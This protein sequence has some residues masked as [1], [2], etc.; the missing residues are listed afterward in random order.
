MHGR[1]LFHVLLVLAVFALLAPGTL[2]AQC[3]VIEIGEP[4]CSG[5]GGGGGSGPPSHKNQDCRACHDPPDQTWTGN[6][7]PTFLCQQGGWFGASPPAGLSFADEG[8]V[9]YTNP[10]DPKKDSTRNNAVVDPA[11]GS[12][13]FRIPLDHTFKGRTT[14]ISLELSFNSGRQQPGGPLGH[15]WTGSWYH[16]LVADFVDDVDCF[17]GIK[18]VPYKNFINSLPRFTEHHGGSSTPWTNLDAVEE[19]FAFNPSIFAGSPPPL[20]LKWLPGTNYT[21]TGI[22]AGDLAGAGEIIPPNGLE[23][24]TYRLYWNSVHFSPDQQPPGVPGDDYNAEP[25]NTSAMR[26]LFTSPMTRG[27]DGQGQ[28]G[29]P[30]PGVEW[31]NPVFANFLPPLGD[32]RKI[33]VACDSIQIR[34]KDGRVDKFTPFYVNGE[35]R[36]DPQDP[37]HGL[38]PNRALRTQCIAKLVETE[39]PTGDRIHYLYDEHSR[40]EAIEDDLGRIVAT[41]FYEESSTLGATTRLLGITDLQGR[42]TQFT[43]SEDNLLETLSMPQTGQV[44]RFEYAAH[45]KVV[46]GVLCIAYNIAE[47]IR[48]KGFLLLDDFKVYAPEDSP[49]EPSLRAHFENQLPSTSSETPAWKEFPCIVELDLGGFPFGVDLDGDGVDDYSFDTHLHVDYD[50]DFPLQL[51]NNSTTTVTDSLGHERTHVF[52]W[53]GREISRNEKV[54]LPTSTET[55]TT[56]Y[57]YWNYHP[58]MMATTLPKG[59]RTELLYQFQ[60]DDQAFKSYYDLGTNARDRFKEGNLLQKVRRGFS[61]VPDIVESF[62]YEPLFNQEW[63]HTDP[64]SKVWNKI[65]D[66]QELDVFTDPYLGALIEGWHIDASSLQG[67]IGLGDENGDSRTDQGVGRLIKD[68]APIVNEG[69]TFELYG[70]QSSITAY[71]YNDAGQ[72]L[73]KTDPAGSSTTYEYYPGNDANGDGQNV[74]TNPPNPDGEGFL[75]KAIVDPLGLALTTSYGY[76]EIGNVLWEQDPRGFYT[77][78]RFNESDLLVEEWRGNVDPTILQTGLPLGPDYVHEQN[79]YDLNDNLREKRTR[80]DDP[81]LAYEGVSP[82]FVTVRYGYDALDQVRVIAEEVYNSLTQAPPTWQHTFFHYDGNGKVTKEVSPQGRALSYVYDSLGRL[83]EKRRHATLDPSP[84]FSAPPLPTDD[85]PLLEFDQDA[86]GNLVSVTTVGETQSYTSSIDYDGFDRRVR[87]TNPLGEYTEHTLDPAGNIVRAVN[88]GKR[89]H[90]DTSSADLRDVDYLYDARNQLYKLRTKYFQWKRNQFDIW[91]ISFEG[92]SES[93]SSVQQF[94][95]DERGLKTVEKDDLGRITSFEHDAAGREK[96][97]SLPLV[98][99]FSNRNYREWTYDPSG[100]VATE[101]EREF[102]LSLGSEVYENFAAITEYDALNRKT[103]GVQ[104][105][106]SADPIITLSWWSSLGDEIKTLNPRGMGTRKYFDTLHREVITQVGFDADFD[107]N[108]V[109]LITST[110]NPDGYVRV[111]RT[112]DADGKVIAQKDDNGNVTGWTFDPVGRQSALIHADGSKETL[113][114]LREGPIARLSKTYLSGGVDALFSEAL[115]E[116]DLALRKTQAQ[117]NKGAGSNLFGVTQETFA[118]DGLGRVT[119]ATALSELPESGGGTTLLG[120]VVDKQYDSFDQVRFDFQSLTIDYDVGTDFSFSDAVTSDYDTLGN[121]TDVVASNYHRSYFYDELKRIE[122]IR[123]D[124]GNWLH[125]LEYTGPGKRLSIQRNQN[126]SSTEAGYGAYDVHRRLLEVD[127]YSPTSPTQPFAAFTYEYDL[128]SNQLKE[129]KLHASQDSHRFEYDLGNRLTQFKEGEEGVQYSV[130]DSFSL[131]GVGN[132]RGH[133][134]FTNPVNEVH[135]YRDESS[136]NFDGLAT[137]YDARGNLTQYGTKTFTYDAKGRIVQASVGGTTQSYAFDAE[138]RRILAEGWVF[139][140]EGLREIKQTK[141][142]NTNVRKA[143]TYGTGLDEVLSC[144]QGANVYT[145]HKNRQASTVALTNAAGNL[146]ETYDYNP[147]GEVT[148]TDVDGGSL[149]GNP[150]LYAGRR[151]DAFSGLYFMRARYYLPDMGRF[152]SRDPI[153]LWGDLNNW[154]NPFNYGGCNPLS[155]TDLF[156]FY[157]EENQ[158]GASCTT[159]RTDPHTGRWENAPGGPSGFRS[160]GPVE[161]GHGSLEARDVA[162]SAAAVVGSLILGVGVIME[163]VEGNLGMAVVELGTD[164][165]PIP[166]DD[167]AVA[168]T[169]A[170]REGIELGAKAAKETGQKVTKETAKQAGEKAA[171]NG[172]VGPKSSMKPEEEFARTPRKSG[173]QLRK[174]WEQKHGKEWPKDAKTGK[175]QDVSHKKPL[176]DGGSNDVGN[177]EPLPHAEHIKR[178]KEAG[179]FQRWGS[180]GSGNNGEKPKQ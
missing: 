57:E 175:N 150:I 39:Y 88:H 29:L 180:R 125:Q 124:N 138:G 152:T 25:A 34:H 11:S 53:Q 108:E 145:Y 51:A 134:D 135:E 104:E 168:G 151:F 67:N 166:F 65:Y 62:T 15:F 20:P 120:S 60:L 176:A 42:Q 169:K 179:D 43:Y 44:W 69:L 171:K 33:V 114:Y 12:L 128:S 173:E 126:G 3:V 109:G 131:D 49:N 37:S 22:P 61:G 52:D 121:R 72:V 155:G 118:Y 92:G 103:R 119:Q 77:V 165:T 19:Q 81:A 101:T 117:F 78:R 48:E 102:S 90:F 111:E 129:Q 158:Y 148:T 105:P 7:T 50:Y 41:F 178:H 154:G 56:T 167:A 123:D 5:G 83:K 13:R 96:K 85:D 59:N 68:I 55:L 76:D 99:G 84:S 73:K 160:P 66:Y 35:H 18:V 142:S 32:D 177:I 24:L 54:V 17:V 132:W 170:A 133:N 147:Y 8:M 164:L 107:S 95:Y 82:G 4:T 2:T 74:V 79:G 136:S 14:D 23:H 36:P 16:H 86:N 98:G 46:D 70:A 159:G 122:E 174:E 113:E 9:V 161:P 28:Q 127:H 30:P 75:E 31:D 64:R 140:H 149:V 47:I 91:Y 6:G 110:H 71:T 40:L 162:G 112:F 130:S 139:T 87:F 115:Y 38:D 157:F 94:A 153:G 156:G 137:G 1:L 26:S 63:S 10:I 93:S 21:V 146:V 141:V 80:I 58:A 172:P 143:F 116:Y 89:A 97:R 144:K 45:A 163:L 106:N 100:N 27:E